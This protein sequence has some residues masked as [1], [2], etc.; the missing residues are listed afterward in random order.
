MKNS[1]E[2]INLIEASKHLDWLLERTK[3]VYKPK[4][5]TLM[6]KIISFLTKIF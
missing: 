4:K 6:Q 3:S 5:K 2:P 1:F